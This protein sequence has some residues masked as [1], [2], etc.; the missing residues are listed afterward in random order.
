MLTQIQGQILTKSKLEVKCSQQ[1]LKLE[2]ISSV[3]KSSFNSFSIS[4]KRPAEQPHTNS[5][6]LQSMDISER[7]PDTR[8]LEP[9]YIGPI[10]G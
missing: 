2:T 5:D 9:H 1:S 7:R 3:W 10:H 8:G 4:N 6:D